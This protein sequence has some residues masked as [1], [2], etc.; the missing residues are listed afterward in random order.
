MNNSAQVVPFEFEAK[1]IR[2]LLIDDQPWFCAKDVCAVLGYVNDSDAIKK[3]CREKGVAKRDSLTSG[4]KQSLTF[5][6]EGNLYRLIIKSRKP[7]AQRFE[8]WVC[9]EVLPAIRKH[10]RYEDASG[11]MGILLDDIIGTSGVLVLDR[12]IEQKATPITSS[13]QRS[14]KHTMKSRL[15]SRFNVQRTDLIP[16]SQLAD[17][18]NFIAAYALEGEWLGKEES[19]LS[20]PSMDSSTLL[21]AAQAKEIT[22]RLNRLGHLFNPLSEQFGDVLGI[23]RALRGLHPRIGLPQSDYVEVIGR[24][25]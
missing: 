5:I 12:V 23:R 21:P 7:E 1:E 18:C 20:L 15:R 6:N 17:A 3:H 8:S 16:A 11:K 13:L 25:A 9:D 19:G 14:F 2:T 22:D 4:G 10:G 24:P